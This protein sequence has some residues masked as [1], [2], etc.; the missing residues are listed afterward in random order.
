V[1]LDFLKQMGLGLCW[2][3]IGPGLLGLGFFLFVFELAWVLGHAQNGHAGFCAM[4]GT[5]PT[6]TRW[7]AVGP[8]PTEGMQAACMRDQ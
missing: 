2:A 8:S 6:E 5:S 3:F 1:L 4:V 7:V